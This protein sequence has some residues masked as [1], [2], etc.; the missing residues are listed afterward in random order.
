ML[1]FWG[2]AFL[3]QVFI[4]ETSLLKA[5]FRPSGV[6]VDALF[7]LQNDGVCARFSKGNWLRWLV[8]LSMHTTDRTQLGARKANRG[9]RSDFI[10]ICVCRRVRGCELRTEYS[11]F[12]SA[13]QGWWV[14][15]ERQSAAGP[16]NNPG[17]R[18]PIQPR[19]P[20]MGPYRFQVP[21]PWLCDGRPGFGPG[22]PSKV[23]VYL[24]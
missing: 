2:T 10:L 12:S 7:L 1:W 8:H 17:W 3:P 11:H 4:L 5:K 16:K 21:F 20:E 23:G 15:P 24:T 9:T 13:E 6:W 19:D 14:W 18:V 22:Q